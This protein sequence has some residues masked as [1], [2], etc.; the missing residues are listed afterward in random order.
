MDPEGYAIYQLT[1]ERCSQKPSDKLDPYQTADNI[2]EK[3]GLPCLCYLKMTVSRSM[4][5]AK[6]RMRATES[7]NPDH[8]YRLSRAVSDYRCPVRAARIS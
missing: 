7:V 5:N 6:R 4:H 3:K 8:E 2:G 1:T